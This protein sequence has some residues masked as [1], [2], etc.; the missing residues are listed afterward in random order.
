MIGSFL[1]SARPRPDDIAVWLHRNPNAVARLVLP[2]G[3]ER[4]LAESDYPP[5]APVMSVESALCYGIFLAIRCHGSLVIAGDRSAW[6]PDWGY[7]TDLAR[8]P[9]AGLVAQGRARARD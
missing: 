9:S 7:L 4:R 1:Y 3:M 2:A 6:N 5:P 8:F